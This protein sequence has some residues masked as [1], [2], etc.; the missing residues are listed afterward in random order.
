MGRSYAFCTLV[1]AVLLLAAPR[2]ASAQSR[3]P[4]FDAGGQIV[5]TAWD[6]FEASD[7]GFGGRFAWHPHRL[8]AAEAELDLYPGD[9]PG[10]R[11]FS[12]RRVE[13]LFGVT[14]GP[15]FARVRLFGKLRAG[16]V[17]VEEAPEPFACILIFPPPL[18]C[19]LAA[20]RTLPAIDVGG[21]IE[22]S[23]TPRTFIRVDAGDRMT[24]YPGPA[25]DGQGVIRDSFVGHDFRFAAGI[26]VRFSP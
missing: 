18:A 26:G 21:G 19:T 22:A 24:R 9:F 15:R 20:G 6:Q 13:G 3:V 23:V 10:G 7:F 5:A 14:A 12:G 2:T 1:I 17:R 11:A 8:L 25:F 16:F 4:R